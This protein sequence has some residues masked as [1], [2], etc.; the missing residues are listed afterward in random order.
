MGKEVCE[1]P[2]QNH[3]RIH[4]VEAQT[5]FNL[6]R[7]SPQLTC[8]SLGNLTALLFAVRVGFSSLI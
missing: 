3:D 4:S 2:F 8:T 1:L 6:L 5:E 7:V